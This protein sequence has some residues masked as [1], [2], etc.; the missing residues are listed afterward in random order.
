[1]DWPGNTA[2]AARIQRELAAKVRLRRLRKPP[3]LVAGVDAAFSDRL[4]FAAACVFSLPDLE[5]ADESGAVEAVRFPYVPGFLTF[6]EG[7]AILAAVRALAAKP[8]L[9]LVDGQG[10][11]HPRKIGIASH[12]GVL[13]DI[14]TIGCAKSRLIGEYKE[15]GPKKGDWSP[16]VED[17]GT[18]G[19]VVRTKAGVKPVFVSPGH[20]VD[21]AGSIA[22]VLETADR[23]RIPEPL[24]RADARSRML[25]KRSGRGPED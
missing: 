3:K 10:V 20:M 21:L 11:A 8:D 25:K 12:L 2:H 23:F 22:L 1:M 19:A 13:L 5:L 16:L 15:P 6:R 24:R 14:P 9:I 7:P 4:V 18:V 17:G